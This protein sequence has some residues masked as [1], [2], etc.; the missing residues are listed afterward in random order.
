MWFFGKQG[1]H[2]EIGTLRFTRALYGLAPSPFLLSGVK[3]YHLDTWDA[4]D[5][6]V[7]AELRK[8]LKER[9]I[10]IFE[11]CHLCFAQVSSNSKDNPS[12]GTVVKQQLGQP[13]VGGS[14][15]LGLGKER[16]EMAISFL[17][18]KANSTKGGILR[19]LERISDPLG[20]V[21]SVTLVE[22]VCISPCAVRNCM[23]LVMLVVVVLVQ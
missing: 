4:R 14:T 22:S 10:K 9:A 16:G 1:E 20:F 18:W 15:L 23:A 5:P 11:E 21:S 17:N 13:C 8:R 2:S 19:K 6:H 7:V 3:D 12:Q